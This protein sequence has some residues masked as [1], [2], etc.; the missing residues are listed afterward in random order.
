[1]APV[2]A[3]VAAAGKAGRQSEAEANAAGGLYGCVI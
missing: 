2:S 3:I 1:M